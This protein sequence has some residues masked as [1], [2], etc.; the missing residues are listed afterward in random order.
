MAS[1]SL[2]KPSS[3]EAPPLR[4]TSSVIRGL[5]CFASPCAAMAPAGSPCPA[6]DSCPVR[7]TSCSSICSGWPNGPKSNE[8]TP[9]RPT[10]PK[11]KSKSASE[12]SLKRSQ[13]QKMGSL[14][15][16]AHTHCPCRAC[17]T[18]ETCRPGPRPPCNGWLNANCP[19]GFSTFRPPMASQSAPSRSA[20]NARAGAPV[21]RAVR[22]H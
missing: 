21:R 19:P 3:S 15:K 6:M 7:G 18:S 4:C 9:P 13:P 16:S 10:R 5:E 17:A 11:G 8:P 22:S 2:P 1:G 14:S 20:P 12:D